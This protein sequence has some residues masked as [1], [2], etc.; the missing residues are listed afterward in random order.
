MCSN[1]VLYGKCSQDFNAG[2]SLYGDKAKPKPF[3]ARFASS[4]GY[5]KSCRSF[6]LCIFRIHGALLSVSSS[7]FH[8]LYEILA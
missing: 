2:L 3:A 4:D 6:L 7:V 1:D 8:P 5:A